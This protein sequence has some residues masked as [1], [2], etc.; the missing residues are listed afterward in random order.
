M[1]VT[2][3]EFNFHDCEV[4]IGNA[5]RLTREQKRMTQVELG[6]DR[7]GRESHRPHRGG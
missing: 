2:P 6:A 4:A 5:I 1:S 3:S 7:V